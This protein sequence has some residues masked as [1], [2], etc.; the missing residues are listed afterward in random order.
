MK[1]SRV[2]HD[3][4]LGVGH[5]RSRSGSSMELQ[6]SGFQGHSAPTE[7]RQIGLRGRIS[8]VRCRANIIHILDGSSMRRIVPETQAAW[9]EITNWKPSCETKVTY[10]F[11]ES[12]MV[13]ERVSR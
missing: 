8:R 9:R 7:P 5:T 4:G 10:S 1:R 11:F 6:T 3:H 13:E 12:D 2:S